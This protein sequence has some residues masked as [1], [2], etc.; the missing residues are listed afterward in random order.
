MI[1]RNDLNKIAKQL[2][3]PA[4]GIAPWPLPKEATQFIATD[5]PCPFINGSLEERLTGNTQLSQ[6]QSAMVCLFP[7]YIRPEDMP[8]EQPI[9]LPRYAWGPDYHLVIPDYLTRFGKALQALDDTVEFEI[10]CD[11]SP[12]ADRYMAYLAGLGVFG[13]NR[14]LIHPTWGSYTSIGTLLTTCPL[15]ADTPMEGTCMSCNSCVRACPG[16]S[17]GRSDFGYETCKSYLTQKKGELTNEEL[18]ILRRS[19]LIWGCD[20]CQEVC[21][22]NRDLPTTPIPEF[23]HIEPYVSAS[24]LEP[25]TNR[26]FK[27]AFGHRA[28]A[29]RGKATLLRNAHIIKDTSSSPNSN[30]TPS[31]EGIQSIQSSKE[32]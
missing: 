26:T 21:P 7:Y 1:T 29:W 14:A 5:N 8:V 11:T 22:H 32:E 13:R 24:E 17:L 25:L 12:L 28:F 4:F 3:I 19:P 16:Q 18:T 6:P 30:N 9:N 15:P 10:H 23:R 20:I 27:A 2:N 31:S